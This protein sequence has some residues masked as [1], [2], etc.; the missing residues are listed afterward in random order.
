M[1]Y[2]GPAR[3]SNDSDVKG[4]QTLTKL[5][6]SRNDFSEVEK[7]NFEKLLQ[8]DDFYRIRVPSNALSPPGRDYIISSVKAAFISSV[9]LALASY[10][11][12]LHSD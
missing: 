6:F 1:G 5:R 3:R 4:S 12:S 11:Q 10:V 9:L 8:S 2:S 7:E